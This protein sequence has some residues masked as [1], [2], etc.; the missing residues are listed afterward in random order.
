MGGVFLEPLLI[1]LIL[2]VLP[3]ILFFHFLERAPYKGW[4]R[5]HTSFN[6]EDY[7]KVIHTLNTAGI[8]YRSKTV[9]NQR[10]SPQF[11]D[12]AIQ[13]DIYVKEQDYHD[14]EKAFTK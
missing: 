5:F 1:W 7:F 10:N 12:H 4:K 11:Y 6:N 3:I 13:I 9:P 14:A 2:I 8:A